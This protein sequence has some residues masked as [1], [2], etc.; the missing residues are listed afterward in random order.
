VGAVMASVCQERVSAMNLK[1]F[2]IDF[3][4][5]CAHWQT[6]VCWH[7]C[8][9]NK[10]IHSLLLPQRLFKLIQVVTGLYDRTNE[11][12]TN[13]HTIRSTHIVSCDKFKLNLAS[14]EPKLL[15]IFHSNS[16]YILG[17]IR[18]DPFT[19]IFTSSI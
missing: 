13:S 17:K 14:N 2:R 15:K 11:Q 12:H 18:L 5:A 4:K 19:I 9:S 16:A 8:R 10:D 7:N 6:A 3:T 1:A